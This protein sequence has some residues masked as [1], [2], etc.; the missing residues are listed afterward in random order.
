MTTYQRETIATIREE[1]EPMLAAHHAETAVFGDE[2]PLAPNL[3]A[4]ER[5]EQLGMLRVYSARNP[6]LIGYS[7]CFVTTSMHRQVVEASEDLLYVLHEYRGKT[8]GVR[9]MRFVEASLA[10]EGVQLLA[11]RSKACAD[12]SIG[13]MLEH[14]G[15]VGVETVY[16]K[17]I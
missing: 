3:A 5:L 9:L 8:V 4:Y 11:R 17:R 6:H 12:L 14:M 1:I 16:C 13:A 7:V 2:F 10:A 15:Y